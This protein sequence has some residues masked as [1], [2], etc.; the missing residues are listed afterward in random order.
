MASGGIDQ[1]IQQLTDIIDSGE[2]KLVVKAINK[3]L[4]EK[5]NFLVA[6]AA[7]WCGDTLCYDL[8]PNL[9]QAYQRFL[10]NPIEKDKTCAAKRA[11]TKA[12]YE[13]DY[14]NESFYRDGL[15]YLQQEPAWGS[16]TDTAVEIRCTCALGIAASNDYRMMLDLLKVLHDTEF[17]VRIGALKAMEMALPYEAELTIRHKILQGDEEPEVIAQAFS[18]LLKTDFETSLDF[19]ASYIQQN[20]FRLSVNTENYHYPAAAIALGESR[21]EPALALLLQAAEKAAQFH[22]HSKVL[23]QAI[24]LSGFDKALNFLLSIIEGDDVNAA[25]HA[26]EALS[27]YDYRPELREKVSSII[28]TKSSDTL[29][30]RYQQYWSTE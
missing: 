12:L 4:T 26:L 9:E 1:K 5:N 3:A 25:G 8:I 16:Y 20:S 21:S 30:R 28:E 27:I 19:V 10:V 23:F 17:Q 7:R 6:R 18:S 15:T 13:L 11:I 29:N 22:P 14:D 24:A 2:A